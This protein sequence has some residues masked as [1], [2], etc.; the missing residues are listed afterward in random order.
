MIKTV[1]ILQIFQT[2]V[3]HIT[4]N[5]NSESKMKDRIKDFI[6]SSKFRNR[7]V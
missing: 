6:S 7:R 4:N 3:T 1:Q 2:D 5:P